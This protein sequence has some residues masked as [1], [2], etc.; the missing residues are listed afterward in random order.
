MG[1]VAT[2][3]LG[4]DDPEIAAFARRQFRQPCAQFDVAVGVGND[5]L[6]GR[7]SGHDARQASYEQPRDTRPHAPPLSLRFDS[8]TKRSVGCYP[9][10]GFT[11]AGRSAS[12][13]MSAENSKMPP[14]L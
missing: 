2:P 7:A 3:F 5:S 1:R 10:Y 6:C 8:P 4:C 9:A 11:G 14:L 12:A 13:G